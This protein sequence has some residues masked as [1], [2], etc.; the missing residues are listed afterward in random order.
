MLLCATLCA[1]ELRV[2]VTWGKL[3]RPRTT[4]VLGG[5]SSSLLEA[6]NRQLTGCFTGAFL[7]C[8]DS[9]NPRHHCRACRVFNGESYLERNL[10]RSR[11]VPP[12]SG[13][14][15]S[16]QKTPNECRR[17]HVDI[18]HRTNRGKQM[19]RRDNLGRRAAPDV[20]TAAAIGCVVNS[21]RLPSLRR[22]RRQRR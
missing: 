10:P 17:Q 21:G 4:V 6:N 11:Y 14:P 13:P 22:R 8:V 12:P 1:V 20:T 16:V 2:S 18:G 15:A 3:T 7:V 9:P 19:R 5:G